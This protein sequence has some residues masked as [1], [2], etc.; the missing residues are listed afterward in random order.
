MKQQS[1]FRWPRLTRM[2]LALEITLVLIIKFVII[3]LLWKAFFS[4]PQAKKMLVP[5]PQ[6][7][8]HLLSVPANK[9]DT[10]LVTDQ[11]KLSPPYLRQEDK[12]G[13]N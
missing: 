9:P 4:Q 5:M 10:N 7:E 13:S 11:V 2:P 1:I 6:I 12:H 3:F 8:Q